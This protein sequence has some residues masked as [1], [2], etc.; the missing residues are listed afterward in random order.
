MAERN[1]SNPTWT[2]RVILEDGRILRL[3]AEESHTSAIAKA[4]SAAAGL[5]NV[6]YVSALRERTEVAE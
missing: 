3:A 1:S 4:E 5:K 6:E 2:P